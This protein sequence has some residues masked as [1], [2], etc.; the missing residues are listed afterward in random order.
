MRLS[1]ILSIFQVRITHIYY[2]CVYFIYE[3]TNYVKEYSVLLGSMQWLTIAWKM[4]HIQEMSLH[5]LLKIAR[6]F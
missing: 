6:H 2:N 4:L 3:Y 1:G 5:L